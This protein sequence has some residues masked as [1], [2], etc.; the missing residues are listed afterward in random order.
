[1][2]L[3]NDIAIDERPYE[4]CLKFGPEY[5]TD[6]ELLA[7]FIRS[8]SKKSSCLEVARKMLEDNADGRGL[9][10]LFGLSS[11]EL[12]RHEGIGKVKAIQLSC[13]ME[14]SKRIWRM[15]RSEKVRFTD[16]GFVADYYM[17]ELRT[18]K[19]EISRVLYLDTKAQL[20]KE[21]DISIGTVNT[22]LLA[23]REI[24]IEALKY[25]AVN[26]ILLHNHPS[27]DPLESREDISATI[28]IAKAG[29]LLGIRLL[30]HIIIGDNSYT[31]LAEKGYLS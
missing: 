20:I 13:I 31:S 1:M 2:S 23:P 6:A 10:R 27:G 18:K 24:F 19:V 9:L 30:D 26:I 16:A 11:Y 5:L 25:E 28:R 8:G 3:K 15:T 29:E 12:A 22:S 17:Q 21:K 4:K 14:L 7:V